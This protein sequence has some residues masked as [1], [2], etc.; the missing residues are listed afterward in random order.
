MG[1]LKTKMG[2]GGRVVIPADARR[3]L[4]M[5]PGD[6]LVV[7]V[8]EGGVRLLTRKE[9]LRQAR[10]IVARHV[11]GR[12]LVGELLKERRRESRRE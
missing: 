7:V 9:A 11:G 3:L 2:P 10:A 5:N 12:D 8:E 1:E 6:H 4:G